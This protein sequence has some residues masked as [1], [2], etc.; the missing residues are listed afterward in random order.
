VLYIDI[1]NPPVLIRRQ[2]R[3]CL[4]NA[5]AEAA[6][7]LFD[8]SR[9]RVIVR[10]EG[11]DVTRGQDARWFLNQISVNDPQLV[12]L[13][14]LYQLHE[15]EEEKSS[16]V[17]KVIRLLN[18]ARERSG[19]AMLM[20][21]HAP[22]ESFRR[23]GELRIAGSRLWTRWPDRVLG[24]SSRGPD[25]KMLPPD[26]RLIAD[27]RPPRFPRPKGDR[28]GWPSLVQLGAPSEWPWVRA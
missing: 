14:P 5:R 10:P 8:P 24:L 23:G 21:S 25:D 13:G 20:E 18:R 27:V 12:C 19:C 11:L 26:W 9:L 17:K 6:A 15:S 7:D 1:E 3:R 4:D 16:D 28:D 22:H 2:L